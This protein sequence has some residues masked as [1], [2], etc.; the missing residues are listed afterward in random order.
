MH[1]H[2]QTHGPVITGVARKCPVRIVFWLIPDADVGVGNLAPV[3]DRKLR[4]AC[5]VIMHLHGAVAVFGIIGLVAK[6][7]NV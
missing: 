5:V 3:I 1:E 4:L 2:A 7:K 6:I